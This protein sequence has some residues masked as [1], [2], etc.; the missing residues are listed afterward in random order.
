MS[1]EEK[2]LRDCRASSNLVSSR[3]VFARRCSRGTAKSCA[4]AVIAAGGGYFPAAASRLAGRSGGAQ[5]GPK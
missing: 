2:G 5:L 4:D 3:S 1:S